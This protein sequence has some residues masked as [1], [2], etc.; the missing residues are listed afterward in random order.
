MRPLARRAAVLAI[1]LGGGSW[2]WLRLPEVQG[3]AAPLADSGPAARSED[4]AAAA[5]RDRA[6]GRVIQVQ[7][8]VTRTLADDRDGSRHQRFIIRSITG[9]S[10]LVAH[11]IDLAPRLEGL[12][13][14]DSVRLQG[15]YVWNDQGGLM[16]WTHHDPGG[17]HKDGYI[18]WRG[19]RYQ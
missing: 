12:A 6:D 8:E 5:F 19:R 14:G 7:G 15:E 18:E 3:P 1:V 17:N 13:R 11:N 2:L 16:H 9:V 4:A 10:L